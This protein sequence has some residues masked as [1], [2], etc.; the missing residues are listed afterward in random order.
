MGAATFFGTPRRALLTLA[1]L[2]LL[3]GVVFMTAGVRGN[4]G[5]VLGFRGTKLA[6]I[7]L[8][9]HAIAMSTVLFQTI[10]GNRILTPS[11]MGFDALFRLVQ[12]GLF[13]LF[14]TLF[15]T[16]LPPYALFAVQT[17]AMML[18]AAL[19]YGRLFTGSGASLHLMLLVGIVL[20]TL[21]R[22]LT[23]FLHGIIDPDAFL[24]LQDQLFANF[25]RA[26]SPLLG[27][28]SAV[29]LCASLA[30]LWQL[31]RFDVLALG[32]EQAVN[33]GL[34]HRRAVFGVLALISLLVSVST[35]LVGPVTFFGLLVANLAYRLMPSHR[36]C[37]VLPAASLLAIATLVG[38]QFALERIFS[39]GT[40]LSIIIEFAGGLL[41]LVLLLRG[42]TR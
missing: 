22:A 27:T 39:F 33:L 15:V 23:T 32:R 9:A 36:H 2:A 35:A 4:W 40:A 7:C 19:L 16:G 34:D 10:T 1:A 21:F 41:F 6:V 28:A 12:T 42:A 8:V 5:F 11:I 18:F 3:A 37:H 24:V 31:R 26:S 38:G 14:G 13:Y 29:I 30:G 25:N 20:G 17:V